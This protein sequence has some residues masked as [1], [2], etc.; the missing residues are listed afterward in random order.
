MNMHSQQ[1]NT[2]FNGAAVIDDL[3]REI[4]I[5]EAMIQRACE[6]LAREWHY[7]LPQ[8]SQ[9]TPAQTTR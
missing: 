2:Q 1:P 8:R 6:N 7:P 3:G 9:P 4:P 5:T